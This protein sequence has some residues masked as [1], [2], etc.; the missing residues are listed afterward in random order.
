VQVEGVKQ[1]SIFTSKEEAS[2]VLSSGNI[3]I[4]VTEQT[5]QKLLMNVLKAIHFDFFVQDP[6]LASNNKTVITTY[7]LQNAMGVSVPLP[8][9]LT[10]TTTNAETGE[11]LPSLAGS[12]NG[13]VL[14][15]MQS[16]TIYTATLNNIEG[17]SGDFKVV[18]SIQ[19][20][21]NYYGKTVTKTVSRDVSFGTAV[22]FNLN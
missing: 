8:S 5:S 11:I 21:Y 2:P 22:L 9:G 7:S 16:G 15:G 18:T 13:S 1:E 6:N 12:T 4:V 20:T 14:F 10:I 17:I 19:T 3:Q